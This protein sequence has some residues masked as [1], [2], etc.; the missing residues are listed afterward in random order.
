MPNNHDFIAICGLYCN[1]CSFKVGYEENNRAHLE[2]IPAHYKRY[3]DRPL[4]SCPGCRQFKQCGHGFK[5][6]AE[7]H[8]VSYCGLC[9]EFPCP[10]IKDFNNDGAP[11]HAEVIANLKRLTQIGED[12]WLSEHEKRW[13]CACGAKKSW[14]LLKC[15]NCQKQH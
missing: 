10:R 2:G 1:A 13:T 15:P 4:Q 7:N 8:N 11:H 6:C 12:A 3:A 14:Y 5:E 9:P